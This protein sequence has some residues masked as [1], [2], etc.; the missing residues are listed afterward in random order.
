MIYENDTVAKLPLYKE[1]TQSI[2]RLAAHVQDLAA[3]GLDVVPQTVKNG[4][5]TMPRMH[6]PML[7]NYIKEIIAQNPEQVQEIVEKLWQNILRSSEEVEAS[8]NMLLTA[9]GPHI[10]E[11][12]Y[13]VDSAELL[14]PEWRICL[15]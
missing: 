4:S 13:R 12:V 1:G 14:L 7:S 6:L 9:V 15:F 2:Q 5:I 10:T 11:G 8:K 3:H